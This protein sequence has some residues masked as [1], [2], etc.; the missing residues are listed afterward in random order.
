M[1]KEYLA[2]VCRAWHGAKTIQLAN[3]G[4]DG[5]VSGCGTCSDID[6]RGGTMPWVLI[7][8]NLFLSPPLSLSLCLSEL[9]SLLFSPPVHDTDKAS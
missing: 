9:R 7:R 1:N 8:I 6:L 2:A 5:H 4:A 3:K